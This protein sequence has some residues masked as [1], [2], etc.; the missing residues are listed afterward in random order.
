MK[1]TRI[2]VYL[3]DEIIKMCDDNLSRFDVKSRGDLIE[4]AIRRL[5]AT[6]DVDLFEDV[7][8]PAIDQSIH[9]SI[10]HSENRMASLL[11]K[12]AVEIAMMMNVVAATNE[13][14]KSDLYSLRGMCVNYVKGVHGK[15][16]FDDAVDL[17]SDE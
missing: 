12:L 11:F 2:G 14:N 6:K 16:S 3:S 1:K 8:T 15:I 17:Q 10:K 7:L 13:I 4:M 9:A 5:V